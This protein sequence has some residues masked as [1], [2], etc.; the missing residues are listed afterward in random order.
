M[1]DNA[2]NVTSWNKGATR[3]EVTPPEVLGRSFAIFY[4]AADRAAGIPAEALAMAA[5]EES[6]RPK[7]G[8]CARTAA[9]SGR[10]W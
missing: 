5:R 7:V 1:L 2:G 8:V 4:T 10:Q 9:N 3:I 6:T